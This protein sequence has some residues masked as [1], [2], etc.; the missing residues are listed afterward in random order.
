MLGYRRGCPFF[1]E[2]YRRF[3]LVSNQ[4]H[5]DKLNISDRDTLVI[6]CDW[7][8][9]QKCLERGIHALYFEAG[10]RDWQDKTIEKNI[11]IMANDWFYQGG[12]DVTMFNGVS[13]GRQFTREI[14]QLLTNYTRLKGL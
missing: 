4:R 5:I 10:L 13:L 14:A 9:W 3:A 1:K 8:L 11:F 2:Q 7:L 12:R 6:S